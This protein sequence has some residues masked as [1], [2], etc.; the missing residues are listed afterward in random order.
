MKIAIVLIVCLAVCSASMLVAGIYLLLGSGW[1]LI[2]AA[3]VAAVL[4]A[5]LYR[6]LIGAKRG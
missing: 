2:V 6:L 1:M 5:I 4:A 3:V